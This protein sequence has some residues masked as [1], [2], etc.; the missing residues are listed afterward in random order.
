MPDIP[1]TILNGSVTDT[2]DRSCKICG[3]TVR[4]QDG[5]TLPHRCRIDLDNTVDREFAFRMIRN[6]HERLKLALGGAL[7]KL[8]DDASAA[9]SDLATGHLRD[10]THLA[11]AAAR[12]EELTGKLWMS[13]EHCEMLGINVKEGQ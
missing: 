13:K 7:L 9:H 3:G 2:F 11:G 6:E 1:K 8:I 5:V 10:H 4:V 12:I